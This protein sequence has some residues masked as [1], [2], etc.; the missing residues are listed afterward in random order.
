MKIVAALFGVV[1]ATLLTIAMLFTAGWVHPPIYGTQTGFRGLAMNQL[2]TPAAQQRQALA[3]ALPDPI[4]AAAPEGPKA[5]QVYQNVQVL[6]DITA[7]QFNTLMAAITEWVA[8]QQG[9]N[10][11][12]NPDNLADDSIYAKKVARRMIQM[13][14]AINTDWKAH[15]ANTG[16]VCWT[17]HRGNPVPQY[18]W[19]DGQGNPQAGGFATTNYGMGHPSWANGSTAM[20]QDP[21]PPLNEKDAVIRVQATK[22]L[23]VSSNGASLLATYE[24]YSL[25]ISMSEGLGVNC[26]FCHNTREFGQ[27]G[28]STPQRVTAWHGI[29]MAENLNISY[30]D[31]LK[32]VLP[33]DRLGKLGDA[34]KLNCMTCHQGASK[35]LLGVSL[36]KDWPELGGTPAK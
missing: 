5:S 28:E 20:P 31:P 35:P 36:A 19:Y 14:Q 24:T 25:M 13:T 7:V 21:Y 6:K 1:I 22:A 34:P 11:C 2:T 12:H 17:C 26:T 9:C 15:V 23:P 27:W 8:P 16:V 18:T 33:A 30:L 4:P 29:R 32:D 10:Y 3:N